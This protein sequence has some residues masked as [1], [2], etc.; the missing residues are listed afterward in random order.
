M[1]STLSDSELESNRVPVSADTPFTWKLPPSFYVWLFLLVLTFALPLLNI[2][3]RP[4]EKNARATGLNTESFQKLAQAEYLVRC[5]EIPSFQS[6]M[7]QK[8]GM[9]F[10]D[11]AGRIYREV[12][13][14]NKSVK[15][16]RRALVLDH[17]R[18]LP[19]DDN[20]LS[21]T[22]AGNLRGQGEGA[23]SITAEIALWRSLYGEDAA[24][25]IDPRDTDNTATRIRSLKLGVLQD[26]ALTDLYTL[27]RRKAEASAAKTRLQEKNLSDLIRILGIFALYGIAFLLGL[28]FL[29]L[30]ISAWRSNSWRLVGRLPVPEKTYSIPG[31][32][33]LDAFVAYL[34]LA[35]GIGFLVGMIPHV[36]QLG[37]VPVT[38]GIYVG[39]GILATLYLLSKARKGGWSLAELGAH[40]PGGVP[41]DILYG[42]ASYCGALPLTLL[43]GWLGT[44][45]IRNH[46]ETAPNPIIPI[47]AG[48]GSMGGRILLFVLVAIAAPLFEELFFRGVLY[49]G[50]RTR[51]AWPVAVA[52]SAACFAIVHPPGDWLQIFGLGLALGSVREMRQSLVP[53]MVIHF[54][55]NS[56]TFLLL[57]SFFTN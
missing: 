8:Q 37:I 36:S 54:C 43:L 12:A 9:T 35:R 6:A 27:A 29:A 51:F 15:S 50:L 41:K 47:I 39:S 5:A 24:R 31:G 13:I 23:G 38:A 2:V 11:R 49:T 1:S 19:L 4:V 55:Q 17:L 18:G 3:Q 30:F 32:E 33:M 34:A 45:L 28:I 7:P 26:Q 40:S 22:L 46:L 20:F 52:I 44:I 53:G 42:V 48:E 14:D 21:S 57:S 16:A 25:Y 10:A 56:M